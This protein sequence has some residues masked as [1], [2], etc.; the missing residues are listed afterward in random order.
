MTILSIGSTNVDQTYYVDTFPEAGETIRAVSSRVTPGGK[1]LNQAVAI[2]RSGGRVSFLSAIGADKEGEYIRDVLSK[3]NIDIHLKE[4]PGISTGNANIVVDSNGENKIIIVEGANGNINRKFLD[5]ENKLIINSDIIVIQNEIEKS[6]N[7]YI[8]NIAGKRNKIILWNPAPKGLINKKYLKFIT[9][10]TP[11][12][13]ELDYYVN[14]PNLSMEEKCNELLE[15]GIKN[16][17]VTLGARGAYYQN[18]N[19]RGIIP[20]EK[21]NAIDTVCAGDTFNGYFI[22]A[23]AI[24][25]SFKDAIKIGNLAAS[26]TV[27]KKGAMNSIPYADEVYC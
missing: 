5:D 20:A 15:S 3:E 24:G 25:K 12:E 16:V 21:V 22:N 7:E 27:Q 17:I 1:G 14:D 9:Y 2:A 6:T 4:I 11:N 8:I 10:F 13:N 26:K 19:E 23:I 18:K